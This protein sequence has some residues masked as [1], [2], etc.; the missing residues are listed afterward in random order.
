MR[1][2]ISSGLN[3]YG[4]ATFTTPDRSDIKH[5]MS[6]FVDRLQQI[7]SNLPLRI[8]PLEVQVFTPTT[9]RIRPEHLVALNVQREAIEE[10]NHQLSMRFTDAERAQSIDRVML[11]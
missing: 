9:G 7:H 5:R 11:Q 10:W 2:S 3:M 1:R 6:R 4:Y 8:V